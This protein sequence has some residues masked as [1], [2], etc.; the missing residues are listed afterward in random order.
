MKHLITSLTLCLF[1]FTLFT[2]PT[3][4]AND[5]LL[6]GIDISEWQGSINFSDVKNTGI[7]IIYIRAAEG[8]D[9]EDQYFQSHYEGA[10]A[11][12]LK[13]G[14]YH[15]ITATSTEEAIQQAQFFYSLI[16]DKQMD[17]LPVMDF[18]SF[19]NLSDEE[20]NQIA[21]TYME[22]LEKLMNVTPM[23]Y[24]DASNAGS[25][26]DD[27]LTI[28]PLWV[29]DYDVTTPETIG[30]WSQWA[31]FQY[32]DAGDISGI[33]GNVD[34]DYF[35]TDVF[36]STSSTSSS[37]TTTSTSTSSNSS[38]TSSSTSTTTYTVQSGD[39]LSQIALQYHCTVSE[40]VALNHILNSNLIYPGEVLYLPTSTSTTSTTHASHT[41]STPSHT[42]ATYTVQSG[43]TLSQIA[44]LYHCT[45]SQLV[46]LNNISNPNL[47]YS[48]EVLTVPSTDRKSVG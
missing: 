36:I 4:Y 19:S 41:S 17:C 8:G 13:V 5:T 34:L 16:K 20:I 42:S 11:A 30:D 9:Y 15:Y 40:L 12:G 35:K 37:N 28:Y 33:D 38:T 48:G 47:I 2:A 39:T 43:D 32:S 46:R 31:G 21:T 6:H 45:I 27:S 26:W 23:L 29:A 44:A 3:L 7:D 10:I 1:P 14:F 18:E 22:T 24:S 25:L